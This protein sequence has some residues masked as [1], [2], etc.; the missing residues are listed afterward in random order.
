MCLMDNLILWIQV[1]VKIKQNKRTK[2]R[3]QINFDNKENKKSR[4]NGS[5]LPSLLREPIFYSIDDTNIV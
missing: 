3:D 2:A 5:T 4:Q 1:H